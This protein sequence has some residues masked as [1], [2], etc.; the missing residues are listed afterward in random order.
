MKIQS[1]LISKLAKDPA[2]VRV[3]DEANIGAIKSS[4]QR[5]GQQ[6]PIVIDENNVVRA[7]NGTL[8]AASELGWEKI[9]VVKTDL[10]SADAIAYAIADN[11]TAELATW[12]DAELT[13]QLEALRNE[14]LE[15]F[16]ATGFSAEDL[17]KMIQAGDIA[18]PD[19]FA[20]FD[21]DIDT[22]YQCPKCKYEWSGSAK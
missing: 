3:H 17:D 4:L 14:D 22:E 5:F 2:N 20:E 21:E 12:N 10:K 1:V 8:K 11:R 19:D 7:G 18:P 6:K 16:Q 13:A 9:S 15:V